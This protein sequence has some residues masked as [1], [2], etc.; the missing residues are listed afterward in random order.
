MPEDNQLMALS[1]NDTLDASFIT[2]HNGWYDWNHWY[3]QTTSYPVYIHDQKNS[4]EVAFKVVSKLLEKKIIEKL[5]L[6]QF[7]ETVNEVSKIV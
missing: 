7:I 3:P 6:K 4:F 2:A 5:T 1:M